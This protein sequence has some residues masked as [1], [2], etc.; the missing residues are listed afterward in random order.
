MAEIKIIGGVLEAELIHEPGRPAH[1]IEL[2][3]G[4]V[5]P[6]FG[7]PLPPVTIW[8]RP[9]HRPTYPVDPDY[10]IPSPPTVWPNPPRPVDPSYGVEGPPYGPD[11]PIYLPPTVGGG[12]I[13]PPGSVWPPLPPGVTGQ[14][15]CFVWIVGVGYRWTTIDTSL[16]PTN[17]IAPPPNIPAHPLPQPPDG[18]PA[19]PTQQGR[20]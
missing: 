3:E 5:D 13:L 18:P 14:L 7:L 12:P 8:P 10:G 15:T 16:K 9:P 20:R 4:P 19:V 2:P 17:P 1:P 6:G 11:L